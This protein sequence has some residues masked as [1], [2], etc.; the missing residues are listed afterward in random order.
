DDFNRGR[1]AAGMFTIKTGIGIG[2]GEVLMGTLGGSGRQDFTVTG[3][4]VNRAAAMEK[5]SKK[6]RSSFIVVCAET[7]KRLG[8]GQ[9]LTQIAADVDT[10]PAAIE[11]YELIL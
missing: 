5:R 2:S 4:T 3:I 8:A 11:G 6:A 7:A 10:D 9:S 1:Q